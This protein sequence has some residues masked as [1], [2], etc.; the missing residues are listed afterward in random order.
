MV[1]DSPETTAETVSAPILP[2]VLQIPSESEKG[3]CRYAE[4][5]GRALGEKRR[6]QTAIAARL[7]RDVIVELS[8]P[9]LLLSGYLS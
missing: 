1:K 8:I 3:V 9:I 7:E 6:D 4:E 2:Q 5:A